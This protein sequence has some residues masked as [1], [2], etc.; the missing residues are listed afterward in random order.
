MQ[1]YDLG[2]AADKL[3]DFMWNDFCDWYIE[4]TKPALYG[5][6]ED[7]KKGALATLLY[8]LDNALRLLHPI[9]PFVTEEIYGY[10]PNTDGK[11]ISADY[12]R[13][14]TKLSYKK[15]AKAFE[16]VIGLIKTVRAMKVSVNCPPAKK[17]H[18][19]LVTENKR[20]VNVNKN[21]IM[22]LA[23]ASAVECVESG[24][25]AAKRPFLGLRS[26]TDFY[27]ARRACQSRRGAGAAHE[28]AG[29]DR[30]GDCPCG[31]K[32]RQQQFRRKSAQKTGRR[33]AREARKIH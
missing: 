10:L 20:L 28:R 4:L 17:V 3:T 25:Q 27:S 29:T 8:V 31:R 7:K 19:Y 24:A 18:I 30:R 1:K 21:A 32:T 23:G 5:E 26:R 15:E 11:I 14:N 9:I 13:Y 16:G 33:R 2:I 22:R 12:P 6:D